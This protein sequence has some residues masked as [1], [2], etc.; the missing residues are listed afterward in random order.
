MHSLK[1]K[2]TLSLFQYVYDK[3]IFITKLMSALL[4]NVKVSYLVKNAYASY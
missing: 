4:E 2:L 3:L 1:L